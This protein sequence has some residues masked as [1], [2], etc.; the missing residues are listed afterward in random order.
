MG[1]ERYFF[2]LPVYRINEDDYLIEKASYAEKVL[3]IDDQSG[4]NDQATTRV[5]ADLGDEF[6]SRFGPWRFN[7]IV[8]YI[9]L[10][11]LENQLRAELYSKGKKQER[12]TR[13]KVFYLTNGE[14]VDPVS[15]EN[16]AQSRHIL[17]AIR[18]VVEQARKMLPHRHIDTEQFEQLA[19]HIQWRNLLNSS[20]RKDYRHGS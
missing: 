18:K 11:F 15:I 9:R 19:P 3:G 16:T 12:R 6:L 10:L 17:A 20:S 8:G 5:I 2:D 7:E 1:P 13:T 14:L 4:G